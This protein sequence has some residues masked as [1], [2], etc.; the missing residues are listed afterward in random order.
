MEFN[1][2]EVNEV[3]KVDEV[4]KISYLESVYASRTKGDL[5][6]SEMGK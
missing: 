1:R 5:G 6:P 4:D 2:Y 3:D